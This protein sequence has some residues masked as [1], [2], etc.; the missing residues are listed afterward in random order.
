MAPTA[1]LCKDNADNPIA[2]GSIGNANMVPSTVDTYVRVEHEERL[3]LVQQA[4][5]D[6]DGIYLQ[7]SL[8]G[9]DAESHNHVFARIHIRRISS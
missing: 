1:L 4:G 6:T 2:T 8:E 3:M 7:I 9:S 5:K